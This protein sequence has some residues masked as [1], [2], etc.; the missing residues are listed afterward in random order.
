MADDYKIVLQLSSLQVWV[1]SCFAFK[2]QF[3]DVQQYM[4]SVDRI[5]YMNSDNETEESETEEDQTDK[6]ETEKIKTGKMMI[7]AILLKRV[8]DWHNEICG[9]LTQKFVGHYTPGFVNRVIGEMTLAAPNDSGTLSDVVCDPFDL[10]VALLKKAS[11]MMISCVED[12]ELRDDAVSAIKTWFELL[13]EDGFDEFLRCSEQYDHLKN[14]LS[15]LQESLASAIASNEETIG[16]GNFGQ[17]FNPTTLFLYLAHAV[18]MECYK[19]KF[20]CIMKGKNVH[21][22]GGN[23]SEQTLSW[24]KACGSLIKWQFVYDSFKGMGGSCSIA[25]PILNQLKPIT[26]AVERY[27]KNNKPPPVHEIY[28]GLLEKMHENLYQE[29]QHGGSTLDEEDIHEF[30]NLTGMLDTLKGKTDER[31][32]KLG[33]NEKYFK[34]ATRNHGGKSYRI[35][36]GFNQDLFLMG[37]SSFANI[38]KCQTEE[39]KE[40]RNEFKDLF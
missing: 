40:K 37:D 2:L 4:E 29:F 11:E 5:G 32:D 8:A 9:V 26:S 23:R 17:F 30:E 16:S 31:L 27:L 33:Q 18:F 39:K 28:I 12:L 1:A 35:D 6:S 13:A 10:H 38:I 25:F 20:V 36:R 19:P 7:K 14:E 34:S 3:L 15:Q 21:T 22:K 24:Q